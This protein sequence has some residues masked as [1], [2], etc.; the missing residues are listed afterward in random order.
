MSNM[1][2]YIDIQRL[3]V[4]YSDFVSVGDEIVVEEKV[5]GA[6]ASFTYNPDADKIVAYSRRNALNET[7]TLQGF[8]EWTQR[9]PKQAV[10]IATNYGRYVLFGEWT[11]KHTI[12]YPER[13]TKKF[14]MF[15]VWDTVDECWLS[16]E[17]VLAIYQGLSYAIMASME[18]IYFV[19]V[20]YQG[21][22]ISWDHLNE[23]VGTSDLEAQPTGEGIVIKN[24]TRLNDPNS[25]LP[26]YIKIVAEKF[27]EVHKDHKKPVDPEELKKKE[28]LRNL[29]GTVVTRRRT[30]KILQKLIE[31]NII[32]EDWDETNMGIIAKNINKLMY[33]DCLKEEPDTV[34]A[35]EGFGKFC[36]SITMDHVRTI[37]KEKTEVKI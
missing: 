6:N 4:K 24:Q 37:L 1:K 33:A 30:E 22:F 5:D 11:A 13:F 17:D 23:L 35:V 20:L 7:N 8:W 36:G 32:P 28:T 25:R 26:F 34:Q 2:H 14:F 18:T 15:D 3:Q 19:P 10:A 27:S 9:L 12:V 31:D 21:Q 16:F 29:V